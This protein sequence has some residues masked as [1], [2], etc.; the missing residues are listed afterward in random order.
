MPALPPEEEMKR[1][2][3]RRAYS[4]HASP[5]PRILNEPE[6][7]HASIFNQIVLPDIV[8]NGRDS[9]R[10]VSMCNGTLTG[11]PSQQSSPVC[12]FRLAGA[13][14]VGYLRPSRCR[15]YRDGGPVNQR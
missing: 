4:S 14:W 13:T 9:R 6:G 10:G 15:P 3:P 8:D 2:A 1:V 11:N 5:I 12:D 7:C